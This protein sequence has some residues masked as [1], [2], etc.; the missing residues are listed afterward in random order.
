MQ[1]RLAVASADLDPRILLIVDQSQAV[2][3][4]PTYIYVSI[5]VVAKKR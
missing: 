4:L 2:N 5:T 1:Q 3:L